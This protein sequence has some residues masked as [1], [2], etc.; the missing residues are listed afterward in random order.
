MVNLGKTAN[1]SNE[2]HLLESNVS[3]QSKKQQSEMHLDR[4]E[5]HPE[6]DYEQKA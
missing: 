5:R 1:E 2:V 6:R 3:S 4:I